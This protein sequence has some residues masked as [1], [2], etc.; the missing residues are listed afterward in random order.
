M[1]KHF[2]E[3]ISKQ[4]GFK[5]LTYSPAPRQYVA[6]T[7]IL[8]SSERQ[9]YFCKIIQKPLWIPK[10]IDSLPVLDSI[11]KQGFEKINYPIKTLRDEFYFM[12]DNSLIVIFNYIDAKQSY[13]FDYKILGKM[14]G[15]IHSLTPKIKV[16][17]PSESFSFKDKEIFERQ[18]L[19]TLAGN[20]NDEVI[21]LLKNLLLK[22]EVEIKRHY[23]ALQKIITE[24]KNNDFPLVIT[25]GDAGGNVLVKSP[26]DL[27]IIDWDEI[28]LAS[29]E[30]DLW[31]NDSNNDFMEG[32]R[33]VFPDYQTNLLARR[34]CICNQYFYYLMYYLADI[35]SDA[36]SEYRKTKLKELEGYFE[37]WIRPYI[38]S[39]H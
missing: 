36:P 17:I 2:L 20:S 13:D 23:A 31:V 6:E 32:Y 25:H 14:I 12:H 4:Y 21:Q 8:E 9:K 34:F 30:R 11:H 1:Q 18:F 3:V 7:Y 10:I 24:C 38:D 19:G 5:G 39:I 15:E 22:Y 26:T 29:A 37:G 27:Y 33:S 28:L 35:L 16:K